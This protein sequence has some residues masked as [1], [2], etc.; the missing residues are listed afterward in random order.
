M[1]KL[2][3]LAIGVLA[4]CSGAK[5]DV[6]KVDI[7]FDSALAGQTLAGQSDTLSRLKVHFVCGPSTGKS[8]SAD[9]NFDE[10]S[11]DGIT[12][13]RLIFVSGVDDSGPN[14]L[15]RDA[16]GQFQ[17]ALSDGGIVSFYKVED[18]RSGEVWTVVFPQTGVVEVHNIS[19]V[20]GGAIDL[21]TANKPAVV[22]P[23]ASARVF[24]ANCVRP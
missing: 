24:K 19:V 23:S 4:G 14:I 13:G 1:K 18:G 12:D 11:D 7:T 22:L 20:S 3:I 6:P 9:G 2:A 15:F 5:S 17:N 21:Y 16:S 10:P 8:F